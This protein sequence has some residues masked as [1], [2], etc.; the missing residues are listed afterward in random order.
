[1]IIQELEGE[2]KK[3]NQKLKIEQD[4]RSPTKR[5][6]SDILDQLVIY[7]EENETLKKELAEC[8]TALTELQS[9]SEMQVAAIKRM[10]N[11]QPKALIERLPA[12]TANN[13]VTDAIK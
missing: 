11:T 13:T 5:H 4:A 6:V 2:V 3:L 12:L 7:K 9:K 1:M 8:K 10:Q